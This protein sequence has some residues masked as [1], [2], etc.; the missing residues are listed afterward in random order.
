MYKNGMADAQA[1]VTIGAK[2]QRQ[3]VASLHYDSLELLN[4]SATIAEDVLRKMRGS[5]AT[6]EKRLTEVPRDRCVLSDAQDIFGLS[7]KI[8]SLLRELNSVLS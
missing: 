8:S 1:P 2:A 5:Q 4:D 3:T 6:E 7:L